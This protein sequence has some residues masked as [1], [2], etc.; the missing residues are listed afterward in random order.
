MARRSDCFGIVDATG[1]N[2]TTGAITI[3]DTAT[4]I[5]TTNIDNRKAISVF[6]MSQNADEIIYLG[7]AGVTTATGYP[8]QPSQ[9]LPFDLSS[10][11]S[12]YGIVATGQSVN[13]RYIEIDNG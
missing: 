5:P 2:F 11:A 8:L 4:K 7:G 6:N 9:G 10:G 12:L 1:T 13:L 3:T